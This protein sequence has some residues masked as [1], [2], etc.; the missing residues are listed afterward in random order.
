VS[1]NRGCAVSQSTHVTV[2]LSQLDPAETR[3]DRI[4]IR[5]YTGTSRTYFVDELRL[6]AK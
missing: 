1:N 2:P 5:D 6:I 4:D 3:F